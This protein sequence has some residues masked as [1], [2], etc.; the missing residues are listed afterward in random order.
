M[1]ETS[2][3]TRVPATTPPRRPPS[4]LEM[5]YPEFLEWAGE[6]RLVE[7]VPLSGSQKGEVITFM[8][9]LD[10]HQAVLGFLYNLLGLFVQW[11]NL[12]KVRVAPFEVQ[13][14][15]DGASREPDL[16]FVATEHLERLTAKRFQGPP[17][18]IVEIVSPDSVKRDRND[19][20]QEY[21]KAGVREYWIID[22]REGHERADFFH[23]DEAS[24]YHLFA[25]EEDERV[26]SRVLSGFWLK[27]AWLWQADTLNPLALLFEIRGMPAEQ[28]VQLLQWEMKNE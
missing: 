25:T 6:D 28:I 15:S 18:L 19:K 24:E 22:P 14:Q 8:P 5:T 3:A 10:V 23:L 20:F 21:R 12:G 2:V 27:P 13:L 11:L 4:R 26:D 17:D 9:P 16:F 7:W 1:M